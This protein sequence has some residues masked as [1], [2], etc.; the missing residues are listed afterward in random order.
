MKFGG[1]FSR[2]AA[3]ASFMS[4]V[5]LARLVE[6]FERSAAPL[7]PAHRQQI[8]AILTPAS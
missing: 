1:R 3:M 4:P 7:E 6:Y 2:K 8:A 5:V